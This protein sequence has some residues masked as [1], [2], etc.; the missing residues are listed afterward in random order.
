VCGFS[1]LA[2]FLFLNALY[3]QDAR[4]F[5]PLHAGLLTLPMA[6]ATGILSPVAGRLVGSRGPRLPLVVAGI[7]ITTTGILLSSLSATTPIWYL[8]VAYVVFGIGFGMLNPPITNAAVSG[9]PRQRAGVAAA[10]ASTSRQVGASLGVAV[11]G[12]VVTGRI[13]GSF[14]IGFP[15][16]SHLGWLIMAGC[17]F[18]VLVLAFVTT[19]AWAK[20]TSARVQF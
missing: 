20:R 5:S 14:A 16:A 8:L 10:I 11:L 17:G 13:V 15:A 3:L 7:G 1:A 4:G 6:A 9:M 2:G 19:S 12:S 18:A